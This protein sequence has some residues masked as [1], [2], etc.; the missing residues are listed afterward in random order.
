M[1]KSKIVLSFSLTA[2]LALGGATG[3]LGVKAQTYYTK[4]KIAQEKLAEQTKKTESL[5]AE[6]ENQKKDKSELTKANNDLSQRLNQSQSQLNQSKSQLNQANQ[7]VSS[8][9]K[10]NESLKKQISPSRPSRPTSGGGHSV[11]KTMYMNASAYTA[12]CGGCS[13]KTATGLDLRANPNLKVIAVDPNIIPIGTKVHVDG[14]GDAIAADTGGAI[15]GNKIDIFIPTES[16]AIQ[17]G[18]K[19]VAVQ[20]LK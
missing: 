10:E 9:K 5:K 14:Y 20:I 18:R 13:G 19:T 8:L 3:F 6:I 1:R 12:S 17:W 2:I 4:T 15:H 7:Q 16:E 11:T